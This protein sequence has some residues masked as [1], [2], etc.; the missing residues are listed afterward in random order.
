MQKRWPF[1]ARC[2]VKHLVICGIIAS[3]SAALVFLLWYPMPYRALLG[4][5]SIYVLLLVV[6]V[7]CGPLLTLLLASPQKSVREMTFDL[8][9]IALIQVGALAYGMH[10]IWLV[11]PAVLAF[12][13]DRLTVVSAT[14]LD[15]SDLLNAPPGLREL[16]AFGVLKISTRKPASNSEFFQSVELSLAG[17]T[18]AMRPSWWQPMSAQHGEMRSRARALSELIARRPGQELVLETAARQA[19]YAVDSLVYLPLTSSKTKEWVALL[20][21]SLDMVGY[22]PVDGFE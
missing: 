16:P 5:G 15:S 22:A 4:V 18:P 12:E 19:G 10:A 11:R 6:D 1:A 20:N 21:D 3:A 14:E 13:N 2:A 7:A 9:L 8:G 17:V